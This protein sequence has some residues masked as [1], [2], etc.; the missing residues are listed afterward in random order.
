LA[1]IVFPLDSTPAY[2]ATDPRGPGL[3]SGERFPLT[4]TAHP[5]A[6]YWPMCGRTSN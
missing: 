6:R 4:A 5:W 1:G 2:C 3:E